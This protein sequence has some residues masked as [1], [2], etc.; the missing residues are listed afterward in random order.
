MA[1]GQI[2]KPSKPSKKSTNPASK[3]GARVIKPKKASLI[4]KQKLVKKHTSGLTA[5]TER[6]LAQKAGHLEMLGG[7]KKA[8]K[9]TD[10]KGKKG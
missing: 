9:G 2:K 5:M 8:A 6:S 7:G 3:R 1:Q 10:K 4:Q